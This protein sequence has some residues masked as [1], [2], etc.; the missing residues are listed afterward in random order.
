MNKAVFA[1]A[2]ALTAG[3]FGLAAIAQDN[4][5]DFARADGNHDGAISYSESLVVNSRLDR[6]LFDMADANDDGVLDEG[7]FQ[8][9]ETLAASLGTD[10]SELASSSE[11]SASS[12]ESVPI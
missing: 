10:P 2:A 6:N 12:S 8:S 1:A 3:A 5:S 11:P 7:E 4:S 9:L